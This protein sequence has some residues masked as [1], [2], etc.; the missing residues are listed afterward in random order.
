VEDAGEDV[1]LVSEDGFLLRHC[2]IRRGLI[3]KEGSN[4][5]L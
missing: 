4:R 3:Q 1:L 5:S 2:L